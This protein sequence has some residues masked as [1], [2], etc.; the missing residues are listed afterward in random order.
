MPR[1]E[2]FVAAKRDEIFAVRARQRLN[3][4]FVVERARVGIPG[5]VSGR[6]TVRLQAL[7]VRTAQIPI[8]LESGEQN[9]AAFR[10][11][12]SARGRIRKLPQRAAVAFRRKDDLLFTDDLQRWRRSRAGLRRR[13]SGRRGGRDRGRQHQ[14]GK[15]GDNFHSTAFRRGEPQGPRHAAKL[16]CM[17]L[18]LPCAARSKR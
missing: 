10:L 5:A 2:I 4:V 16:P 12:H 8:V 6:K 7:P 17:T 9:D 14:P 1:T 13:S 3:P 15:E 18:S 11:A